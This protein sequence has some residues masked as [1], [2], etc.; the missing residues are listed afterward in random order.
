MS[1]GSSGLNWGGQKIPVVK[2]MYLLAH[3]VSYLRSMS[4]T[5]VLEFAWDSMAVEA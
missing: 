3:P 4:A 5:P 2:F 1:V